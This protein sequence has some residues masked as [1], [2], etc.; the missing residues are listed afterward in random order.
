[1][2]AALHWI[3]EHWFDL[4]QTVGI[5]GGLLFTAYTVRKDERARQIGNLIAI[6]QQ[7]REIW[8]ELYERPKLVRVLSKEVDLNREPISTEEWLFVK[9]LI[10]HLDTVHRAMKAGMF[11]ELEGLQKDIKDFFSSPIPRA[12][13]EKLKWL[14]DDDF[15]KFVHGCLTQTKSHR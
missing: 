5:I 14:Q 3:G 9:F 12:I 6:K 1:M 7:N 11:V 4:L 10:L 15:V 2:E 13:W 8:K